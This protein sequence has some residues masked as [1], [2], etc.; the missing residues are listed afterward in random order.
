[1]LLQGQ[2]GSTVT[3]ADVAS[4]RA[5]TPGWDWTVLGGDLATWIE[6]PWPTLSG[7]DVVIT[8]AGLNAVAEVAAARKPAIVI[9]Q[10]R[11]HEEQLATARALAHTGLAITLERWPRADMWPELLRSALKSGG[12]RWSVWSAGDGAARAAAIIESVA[13]AARATAEPMTICS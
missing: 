3:T 13:H 8:H 12:E 10:Q 1:V 11:P 2:G 4:A 6:D 9:P 5:A 7:A